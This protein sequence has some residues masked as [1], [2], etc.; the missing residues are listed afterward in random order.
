MC[1]CGTEIY[2]EV[3]K[4]LDLLGKPEGVDGSRVAHDL[5][6]RRKR[7]LQGHFGEF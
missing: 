2:D 5:A 7:A 3:S 1:I 4:I 6:S